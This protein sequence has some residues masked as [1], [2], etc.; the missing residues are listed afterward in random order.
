MAC[1]VVNVTAHNGLL[2]VADVCV[3]VQC[4]QDDLAT[5]GSRTIALKDNL[6][7]ML[8]SEYCGRFAKLVLKQ[9]ALH[10][11]LRLTEHTVSNALEDN[12]VL[13]CCTIQDRGLDGLLDSVLFLLGWE[14]RS[15]RGNRVAKRQIRTW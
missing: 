5:V 7:V 15:E 2:F 10:D 11:G 6:Y 12:A 13:R 3:H 8:A 14:V 4:R 1:L 9:F